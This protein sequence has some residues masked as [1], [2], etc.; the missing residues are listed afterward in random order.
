MQPVSP[1]HR[2]GTRQFSGG[3]ISSP[4]R[5]LRGS[6][7]VL[8][9]YHGM[10]VGQLKKVLQEEEEWRRQLG[11]RPQAEALRLF[12]TVF[13]GHDNRAVG[14]MAALLRKARSQ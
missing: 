5:F 14:A 13:D 1:S 11:Q 9:E 2:F 10:K 8:W 6:G 12:A 3:L 4:R 7:G